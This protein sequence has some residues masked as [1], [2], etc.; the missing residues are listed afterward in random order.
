M[1]PRT[2]C[3]AIGEVLRNEFGGEF[4]PKED[5]LDSKGFIRIQKKHSTLTELLQNNLLTSEE[6]ASLLKFCAVRNPFDSLVSL[7]IKKRYKYQPLLSDSLSWVN[8]IPHYAKDMKYCQTHSFSS[9]IF[10][11]CSKKVIKY[12]LGMKPSM[13]NYYTKGVDVVMRYENINKDFQ[14]VLQKAGISFKSSIPIVNRTAEKTDINYRSY[15]SN[16]SRKLVEYAYYY[17]LK[18]YG[19]K[20]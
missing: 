3:T 14:E 4:L 11:S 16:F 13:Y 18:T 20:F 10:K 15:Y 6:A 19:Y 2:A 12:I 5:I 1:T 9:W 7:Y 17:D 8:R